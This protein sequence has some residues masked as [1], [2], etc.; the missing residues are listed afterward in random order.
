MDQFFMYHE[1]PPRSKYDWT[2]FDGLSNIINCSDV[3]YLNSLQ[4]VMSYFG[5]KCNKIIAKKDITEIK[6]LL[7]F[8]DRSEVHFQMILTHCKTNL[9]LDL[10]KI[11]V[12]NDKTNA[13]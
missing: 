3:D 10:E 5:C 8:I 13:R 2:V 4:A 9:L 1:L 7:E 6:K 11:E 12:E